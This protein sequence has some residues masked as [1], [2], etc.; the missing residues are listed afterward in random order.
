MCPFF[1][2][3]NN[4]LINAFH[5]L[6]ILWL[7]WTAWWHYFSQIWCECIY[8]IADGHWEKVEGDYRYNR[9][10][11]LQLSCELPYSILSA[12]WIFNSRVSNYL[13]FLGWLEKGKISS[14]GS[15]QCVSYAWLWGWWT[16]VL[17][18]RQRV[19]RLQIKAYYGF[20]VLGTFGVQLCFVGNFSCLLIMFYN[21]N[22]TM[23]AW[24]NYRAYK[25]INGFG[26]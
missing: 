9:Q 17:V 21:L 23:S 7:C 12:I 8:V 5:E 1:N 20:F 19:V 10:A 25:K 14:K 3:L 24:R 18:I 16:L 6:H 13:W 4:C 15:I 22:T 26:C 2:P 11:H